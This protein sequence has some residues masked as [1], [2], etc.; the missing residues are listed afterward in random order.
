MSHYLEKASGSSLSRRGF[1]GISAL[2]ASALLL[3]TKNPESALA[4]VEGKGEGMNL[5]DTGCWKTMSCQQACGGRCI[6]K[7]YVVDGIVVRQKTDDT[8]PDSPDYPQQ[9]GCVR[10]KTLRTYAFGA[11]RIKYPMKRK[12]WSPDDPH[13][14]LRGIDDW[15]RISWD[16][17]L[18]Y[19]A[20]EIKKAYDNYGPRSILV[21]GGDSALQNQLLCYLG[22]YVSTWDSTSYGS[23][24]LDATKIGLPTYDR[25]GAANDRLDM[26]YNAE[27]IVCYSSNPAWSAPGSSAWYFLQAKKRGAKF[28]SV[29]P[30]R[31]VSADLFDCKN[32][33][34]RPGTDTAFLLAVAYEMLRLD[35]DEGL[36]D[37]DF[38]HRCCVGFDA[39]SMPAAAKVDENFEDYVLGK[40]DGTPKTPEW[41]TEI[42]G[43]PT[44]DITY[45]ARAVGKDVKCMILHAHASARCSGSED[46]P[47]LL[48]TIGCMGG[49]YGKPG[50]SC[51]GYY[52]DDG[53]DGANV[54]VKSGAGTGE[55]APAD[56]DLA[57]PIDDC[58]CAS[59]VWNAVLTGKYHFV[60]DVMSSQYVT[61]EDRDIDIHL[62]DG[63]GWTALRSFPNTVKG[64]EA[65]RKVDFV[66]YRNFV[67][68]PNAQ[69]ADII[70]PMTS[71]LE[72]AQLGRDEDCPREFLA[73]YSQVCEPLY[74]CKTNMWIDNELMKRLGKDP[75][76][77]HPL[78]EKQRLFNQLC[79]TTVVK[80]DGETFENLVKITDKDIEDWGVEGKPQDGRISL[81]EYGERGVYQVER[82]KDDNFG[83]IAYKDFVEDPEG[84]PLDTESGKFE[85]YSQ[86]KADTLN[87]LGF[88]DEEYKGYPTYH[89]PTEGYE[90][91]FSDWDNKV[92][93]EYPFL[94]IEPHYL[95]TGNTV[96]GNVPVL[97]KVWS[98]PVFMNPD[99]A[100][101]V[102]VADGDTVLVSSRWGKILRKVSTTEHMMP[103]V[104]AVPNGG[105]P[106][107]DEDGIDRG[108]CTNTL[109]G[110][111]PS[112]LGHSPYNNV[113]VKVEKW[114][115]DS[116]AADED[117]QII[118]DVQ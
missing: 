104:V 78:S 103:G 9:R 58:I 76:E 33:Y 30:E 54:L 29:T 64:V 118:L 63:S 31:N 51:G 113:N 60:G 40:Y 19:T 45:F 84:H 93:G 35:G 86:W 79:A 85:I 53:A 10:G 6:N 36:V 115:G 62:I 43:T 15:E 75:A 56:V 116:P 7:G 117:A 14:E 24:A 5:A 97:A 50:H 71:D 61:G 100:Q 46:L 114:D 111:P 4:Q 107:F 73:F 59:E 16:E 65:M 23:Y 1:V 91:T 88:C 28:I 8:H 94:Q 77:L 2:A 42:C 105:W 49:H 87:G 22:G 110:A 89:V 83:V 55:G 32:I 69:Y 92:K 27:T 41:A 68:V 101:E 108:G 102:G 52:I 70:L 80:D 13:G 12:H 82:H 37:W 21:P 99:D 11:D 72:S 25:H 3:E 17:A 67:P 109:V 47:Q 112:G 106:K 66:V 95:R 57:N 98:L 39:E 18:D 48:M 20:N 74:E 90:T 44:D 26:M 38:L 81:E 34:V 96:Y